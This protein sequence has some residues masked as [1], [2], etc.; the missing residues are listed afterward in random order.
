MGRVS[1]AP[2]ILN[3]SDESRSLNGKGPRIVGSK[4]EAGWR[5]SQYN[6]LVRSSKS[7]FG[8]AWDGTRRTDRIPGQSRMLV[9][10]PLSG[11]ALVILLV[12][13]SMAQAQMGT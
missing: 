13:N 6:L 7:I 4:S 10:F 8:Q 9:A 1:S 5:H 3:R 11:I 12:L 2:V